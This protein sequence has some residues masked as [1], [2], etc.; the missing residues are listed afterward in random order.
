VAAAIVAILVVGGVAAWS[1]A[2]G[3][4]AG[5]GSTAGTG[6]TA[7][8]SAAA[9]ADNAIL[10]AGFKPCGGEFCPTAPLCWGGVTQISGNVLTPAQ[11]ACADSHYW[12]T[13]AVVRLPSDADPVHTDDALMKRADLAAA[14]S[15]A[16]MASRSRHPA[17]T[18]SW[19]RDAWPIPLAGGGGWLVHCIARSPSGESTGSAF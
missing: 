9:S 14:C 11:V 12:E 19:I 17:A 10:Q 4:G 6:P 13:F 2:R 8:P 3:G 18:R 7:T 15:A 16:V 5:T 1:I